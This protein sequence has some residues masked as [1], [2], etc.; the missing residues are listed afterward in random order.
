MDGYIYIRQKAM[1][2]TCRKGLGRWLST[3]CLL[4]RIQAS[5]VEAWIHR[6]SEKVCGLITPTQINTA[7]LDTTPFSFKKRRGF[8]LAQ[9]FIREDFRFH[10]WFLLISIDFKLA[11][12]GLHSSPAPRLWVRD[13]WGTQGATFTGSINILGQVVNRMHKQG[14]YYE[15]P[16]ER[17]NALMIMSRTQS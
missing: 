17:G 15:H 10:A 4:P 6:G 9:D 13:A 11:V 1:P 14:H 5:W 3:T 2:F 8:S 12:R 7:T 16:K